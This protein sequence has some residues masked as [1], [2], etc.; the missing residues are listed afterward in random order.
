MVERILPVEG[1]FDVPDEAELVGD[2]IH[3]PRN[4]IRCDCGV[5]CPAES[6]TC[7]NCGEPLVE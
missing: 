2:E 7:W 4:W 5:D 6:E 3:D 1:L